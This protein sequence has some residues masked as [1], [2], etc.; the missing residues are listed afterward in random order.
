METNPSEEDILENVI[1]EFTSALRAGQ[2]PSIQQYQQRYPH[3]AEDIADMLSSISMIEQLKSASDTATGTRRL[4]DDVSQLKQIGPYKIIREVGRGGMGIVFAAIH[5]G[6]GRQVAIKVL[7][8]P[9]VDGDQHVER[10]HREAQAA[11][12][13]HHTNIVSVF[14][15]GEGTGFHYYV[16]DYVDGEPLNRVIE[17]L[18]SL[19]AGGRRLSDISSLTLY[20]TQPLSTP[21]APLGNAITSPNA[22][23][24]TMSGNPST[25]QT[26]SQNPVVSDISISLESSSTSTA[27]RIGNEKN[28]FRWAARLALQMADAL[29]HAH[30]AGILHRDVK[31]SNMILDR[32]GRIW[33][34][35]F[36]LAKDTTHEKALTKTGDVIGTPQ[37]LPPESLEAKYD[38]RSEVY[39]IGLVLYE[40]L[41]FQPA[42]SGS[43]PAEL[44]RAIASKSPQPIRKLVST[45]PRDLATIVDKAISKDPSSRYQ[46][47]GLLLRDLS[48]FLEERAI[49][50]RRPSIFES[51]LRWARRNPL[52]AT[53]SATSALL[54]L[55]V[56]ISAS[57]GYILT[58]S[59]LAELKIQKNATDTALDQSEKNYQAMKLQYE[60]ADSNVELSIEAFDEMFKHIISRG[61]KTI[62]D[63]EV[64]GLREISGLEP[65]ITTEDATFLDRMVK[66]YEQFAALNAENEQLQSEAA[67]AYRRVG[68]IYQLVGQVSS[69]IEA[70]EKSLSLLPPVNRE[71]AARL[72]KDDLLTRARTQNELS[73]AYRLNAAPAQA[74]DWSR[75]S[76]KLLEESSLATTDQ[77]VRFELARIKSALGFDV[78][79][80]FSSLANLP[81]AA[82]PGPNDRPIGERPFIDRPAMSDRPISNDRQGPFDRPMLDRPLLDRPLLDR[83]LGER[84]LSERPGFDASRRTWERVNRP[85]IDDAIK[86][87]DG[88]AKEDPENTDYIALRATCYWC[89]AAIDLERDRA[90]Q[91]ENRNR[92]IA[93]LESLDKKKP[94]NAEFQ[95]L[96]ALA[97][98]LTLPNADQQEQNLV[99]RG[100]SIAKQLVDEHSSTLD[101]HHLY[102]KLRI[103]QAAYAIQQ[104]Q[105]ERAFD[106]LQSARKSINVLVSRSFSDRAFA[107]T[108]KALRDELV[109]LE[110]AYREEGNLRTA[111]EI[112]QVLRQLRRP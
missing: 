50:A 77:E 2:N 3:L 15:A 82:R 25:S 51:A 98:S 83:P 8:T 100:A 27:T 110:R 63:L 108:I 69:A 90:N 79:K 71:N 54:L 66:F 40:L 16:M 37:Y 46:T 102:A 31:P 18:R 6:L 72:V 60:R 70:Y 64:E 76:I 32:A 74:Q 56:A 1:A 89:L 19:T 92:A 68:N 9:L 95:Y 53:L 62:V 111:N 109:V 13:L 78:L 21:T 93:E 52:A 105:R 85:M 35:D 23:A 24:Q 101:Y 20:S 45:I 34:T 103:K 26:D 106:Y 49:T 107:L 87:L 43:S 12:K 22:I 48:A 17:R 96:L 91:F 88:L 67:K 80:A 11:A 33:I 59:A 7:P 47:A 30:T 28:R 112:N 57:V 97:C 86:I 29:S 44:I 5:E 38:V 55:L 99:E 36:G 104:N 65:S 41:C 10:F 61:S 81:A 58:T 75:R 94:G 84:P 39:G 73:S 4:L 42:Y 14:G